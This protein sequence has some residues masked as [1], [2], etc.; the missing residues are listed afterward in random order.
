MAVLTPSRANILSAGISSWKVKDTTDSDVAYYAVPQ[1]REGKITIDA[2]S[3]MD[4]Q[5]RPIVYAYDLKAS[6]QM[7]AMRTSANFIKLCDTLLSKLID[8]KIT[9]IN[10]QV[11][12][13]AATSMSPTGFGTELEIVSDKDMNDVMYIQQSISR[14]LTPA[15]YNYFSTSANAPADG[16]Q[17]SGDVL[18]N[19]SLL[20]RADV[21]PAGI[22]EVDFGIRGAGTYIDHVTNLRNG[23]FNAKSVAVK[24]ARGQSIGYS[25]DIKFSCE[26]METI[27]AQLQ[28]WKAIAV[29]DNEAKVTFINGLVATFP[30]QIGVIPSYASE[31][32]SD[33]IAMMKISGAGFVPNSSG[34]MDGIWGS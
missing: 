18:Y 9:M 26:G 14:I 29:R 30:T 34:T 21:V 20:T 27:E 2:L 5:K 7:F 17:T 4:S 24:D 6:V 8:Y 11:F 32:D 28:A 23:K 19:L 33:D 12:S 15:E 25:W 22:S 13:S 3:T 31:K 16:T 10:G 1:L